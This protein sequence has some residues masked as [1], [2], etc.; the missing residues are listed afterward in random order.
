M[1]LNV[2]VLTASVKFERVVELA[3]HAR[4]SQV[5]RSLSFVHECIYGRYGQSCVSIRGIVQEH[6]PGLHTR[7][8]LTP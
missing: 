1:C 5:S 8:E 2:L 6:V 7:S 4:Q 3:W